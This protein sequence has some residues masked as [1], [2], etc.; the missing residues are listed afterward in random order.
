[1]LCLDYLVSATLHHYITT[2]RLL[3][4]SQPSSVI[5]LDQFL[6]LGNL[7]NRSLFLL[8][9]YPMMLKKLTPLARLMP[10]QKNDFRKSFPCTYLPI[11][12]LK[13][14]VTNLYYSSF[15]SSQLS[16]LLLSSLRIKEPPKWK[17]LHFTSWQLLLASLLLSWRR[18]VYIFLPQV[19]LPGRLCLPSQ[20]VTPL[21]ICFS[22]SLEIS[23]PANVLNLFT[24]SKAFLLSHHCL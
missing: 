6:I 1:M 10:L 19:F 5:A 7:T 18:K 24:F 14:V 13:A 17:S 8:R 11:L 20:R 4:F 9:S 12:V 15:V 3:Y 2:F 21:V 22:L 16:I 23:F